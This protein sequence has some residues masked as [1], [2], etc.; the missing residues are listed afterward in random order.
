MVS[1]EFTE[2]MQTYTYT[3]WR[4]QTRLRLLIPVRLYWGSTQY[5]PE[6]QWLLE[7]V[8]AE[9]GQVKDFALSGFAVEP[10]SGSPSE[11]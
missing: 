6:P 1:F 11:K 7:A 9:T 5:H 10:V 3:N 8:D 4:G 2:T